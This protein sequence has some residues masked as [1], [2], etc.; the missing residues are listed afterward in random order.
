ML[1]ERQSCRSRA[2]SFAQVFMDRSQKPA[3][4]MIGIRALHTHHTSWLGVPV[5]GFVSK[6]HPATGPASMPPVHVCIIYLLLTGIAAAAGMLCFSSLAGLCLPPG[7]VHCVLHPSTAAAQP[8]L[9]LAGCAPAHWV[10][11]ALVGVA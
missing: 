9:A 7:A 6:A 10:A 11:S 1:P 3:T 8:Q 2:A 5:Q 4:L